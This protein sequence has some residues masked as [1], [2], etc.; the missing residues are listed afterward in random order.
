MAW[1]AAPQQRKGWIL[2]AGCGLCASLSAF[3]SI[4]L[5]DAVRLWA[6]SG[7]LITQSGRHCHSTL[8]GHRRMPLA[9]PLNV[10]ICACLLAF[11]YMKK[12]MAYL[13]WVKLPA[14]PWSKCHAA[15]G[16]GS[17]RNLE[18]FISLWFMEMCR[19]SV[20]EEDVPATEAWAIHHF[21]YSLCSVR[22][23]TQRESLSIFLAWL[24]VGAE[25]VHEN[26][27]DV[28]CGLSCLC[29]RY[30]EKTFFFYPQPCPSVF[31]LTLNWTI[32]ISFLVGF[33]NEV[34]RLIKGRCA[35][36]L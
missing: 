20:W 28:Q 1:C 14:H 9:W 21:T 33:I 25:C 23:N 12:Q 16:R 29:A 19:D 4:W 31:A 13:S 22:L 32:F 10:C 26:M 24:H 36:L 3:L 5:S 8:Q 7:P 15:K 18:S 11:L 35:V 34:C 17:R 2:P 6:A 30:K 27:K